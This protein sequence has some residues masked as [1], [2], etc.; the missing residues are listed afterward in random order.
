MN[1]KSHNGT[2]LIN[3]LRQVGKLIKNTITDTYLSDLFPIRKDILIKFGYLVGIFHDFGK[4]TSFFQRHLNN[5]FQGR[6]SHHSC[7][8]ALVCSKFIMEYQRLY[9]QPSNEFEACLP[10]ISYFVINH[11]HGNLIDIMEDLDEDVASGSILNEWLNVSDNLVNDLLMDANR[12][13]CISNMYIDLINSESIISSNDT[14]KLIQA[15]LAEYLS[16]DNIKNH[17]RKLKK[18]LKSVINQDKDQAYLLFQTIQL[19]YSLLIEYDKITAGELENQI[20]QKGNP[21]FRLKI[22]NYKK[23]IISDTGKKKQIDDTRNKFYQMVS[24]YADKCLKTKLEQNKSIF[25]ITAPTGIGKTI[26]TIKFAECLKKYISEIWNYTPNVL[27]FLPFTTIIDQN[28][29]ILD[30]IF[31]YS[32]GKEYLD[33]KQKY[34]LKHHHLSEFVLSGKEN[35]LDNDKALLFVE[36]WESAFVVSTFYQF[37]QTIFGYQN[38]ILKKFNKLVNAIVILD[39]VQCFPPEYWLVL[40]NCMLTLVKYFNTKFVLVTATQ[41]SLFPEDL[42]ENV[43]VNPDILYRDLQLDRIE[44]VI[45]DTPKNYRNVIPEYLKLFLETDVYRSLMIVSNTIDESIEIVEYINQAIGSMYPKTSNAKP[46]QIYYLSTNI[47]PKVRLNRIEEIKRLQKQRDTKFIIVSTHLIEAGIDIDI[48]IVIRDFAPIDCL[49][50]VAGRCNRNNMLGTELEQSMKGRYFVYKF[51]DTKQNLY[52]E[53]IY[54]N[55]L[56]T[57]SNIVLKSIKTPFPWSE[58]IFKYIS[59]SYFNQVKENVAK[60]TDFESIVINLKFSSHNKRNKINYISDFKIIKRGF[61]SKLL[62]IPL[63]DEAKSLFRKFLAKLN[64]FHN[65]R[66]ISRTQIDLKHYFKLKSEL[67]TI[68]RM[69]NHYSIELPKYIYQTIQ[70]E[71]II[72]PIN[73]LKSEK[74][75][76]YYNELTGF[77]RKTKTS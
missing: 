16:F 67:K 7:L 74:L 55:T 2:L 13:T 15:A 51:T 19:I 61:P 17:I 38:S 57:L 1:L 76:Q 71:D 46:V 75:S 28:Y 32:L 58:Q 20:Y 54:S 43:I 64:E 70:K 63:D 22:D 37:F 59:D 56:L 3:H 69:M 40:R 23:D 65:F 41:P 6:E 8:S 5:G 36:S 14:S 47:P 10:A 12:F 18:L 42:T 68:K 31:A 72:K 11:H 24:Q 39:E 60:L 25:T 26:A 34:L 27:Y 49:V 21:I 33:S 30:D 44:C 29:A 4:C 66:S 48:D 9:K 77:I 62:F 53:H 52:C 73:I 35:E 45:D 50:Q